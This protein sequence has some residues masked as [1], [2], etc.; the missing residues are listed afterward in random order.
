MSWLSARHIYA[1]MIVNVLLRLLNLSQ[2]HAA[3]SSSSSSK[4]G[5]GRRQ[6]KAL[7]K[8]DETEMANSSIPQ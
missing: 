6:R 7:S 4:G 5:S 1:A 8:N 2:E 3:A